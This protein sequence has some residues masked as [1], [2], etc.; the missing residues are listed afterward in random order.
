MQQVFILLV[1]VTS[2][3]SS[4]AIATKDIIEKIRDVEF[5]MKHIPGG[6]FMMGC[7]DIE[8]P[9]SPNE[10]MNKTA[11][12]RQLAT[13]VTSFYMAETETTWALYQLCIDDR[14]CRNNDTEGGDNGWGKATRPVIEVS[15]EDVTNEFLP[16]LNSKTG[17][18]YR[19]PTEAEWE[20][21]ARAGSTTR[22]P[23]GAEPDCSK[24]RY[25]YVSDDCG[26]P[27]K[28]K[29]VKTFPPNAFGL[30]DM[31]GNVW[32]MVDECWQTQRQ[33]STTASTQACSEVVLRG[34]SWLN[35]PVNARTAVRFRHGKTFRESGDGFRLALSGH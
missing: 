14:H 34:G 17:R 6:T 19:L 35:A 33:I 25:G 21:A 11:I 27:V 18:N 1:F 29:E 23:W 32:E 15:W 4:N 16:W 9:C 8:E 20:Y 5:V 7:A 3:F 30:F 13:E 10:W 26:K 2:W 28:T 24:A 12:M 31:I 22:Y